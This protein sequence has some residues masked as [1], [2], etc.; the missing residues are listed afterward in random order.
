M[1]DFFNFEPLRISLSRAILPFSLDFATGVD[2]C[3]ILGIAG[4]FDIGAGGGGGGIAFGI[5]AGG[6]GGG[7]TGI[8]E[9]VCF[10]GCV[11]LF[12]VFG[13]VGEAIG[14]SG[15]VAIRLTLAAML[16]IRSALGSITGSGC[17]RIEDVSTL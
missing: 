10:G 17:D 9:A 8:I 2:L 14:F 16:A 1:I 3:L 4:V 11:V 13:N 7:G 15:E 5:G 6:G 12:G